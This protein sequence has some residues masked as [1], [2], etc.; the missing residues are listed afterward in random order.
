MRFFRRRSPLPLRSA[1]MTDYWAVVGVAL[2]EALRVQESAENPAGE[3]ARAIVGYFRSFGLRCAA[4]RV[5]DVLTNAID[6]GAIDWDMSEVSEAPPFGDLHRLVRAQV[7]AIPGE[8][9]WYASG[10]AFCTEEARSEVTSFLGPATG[11]AC[12]GAALLEP[13]AQEPAAKLGRMAV[14]FAAV[15]NVLNEHGVRACVDE[16]ALVVPACGQ[17]GYDV[18]LNQ[19]LIVG[20]GPLWHLHTPDVSEALFLFFRGLYD[21]TRLT[22]YLTG[23]GVYYAVV[24]VRNREHGWARFASVGALRVPWRRRTSIGL[25]NAH[26][27]RQ[28]AEGGCARVHRQL[29]LP[30]PSDANPDL[31]R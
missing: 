2:T 31:A 19:D 26:L 6:D 10:K 16:R 22:H 1:G 21:G 17:S 5:R 13:S 7:V 9:I 28:Q 27:S 20:F 11:K 14:A 12:G 15:E 29:G 18:T 23:S 25:L 4:G 3:P 24:H 30:W 8:G